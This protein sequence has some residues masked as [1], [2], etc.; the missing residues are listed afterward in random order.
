V[1]V[2]ERV[3]CHL[4]GKPLAPPLDYHYAQVIAWERPTRGMHGKSGSSLVLRERTGA[5][6]H[7]TCVV[8]AQHGVVPGQMTVEDM[9]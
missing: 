9:V 3:L 7:T 4:C 8:S 6:A 5:L 2:N 1:A